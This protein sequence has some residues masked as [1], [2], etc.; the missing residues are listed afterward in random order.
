MYIHDTYMTVCDQ[1]LSTVYIN[2]SRRPVNILIMHEL[3]SLVNIY[4]SNLRNAK[5]KY[6]TMI[7]I[8]MDVV[9]II[10]EEEANK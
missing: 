8:V 3:I 4:P 2:T 9:I 10:G 6:K 1:H 7:K 5:I